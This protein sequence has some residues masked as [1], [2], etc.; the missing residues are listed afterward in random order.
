VKGGGGV[1][2]KQRAVAANDGLA[3]QCLPLQNVQEVLVDEFQHLLEQL[4]V[5]TAVCVQALHHALPSVPDDLMS[6]GHVSHKLEG[7]V[8]QLHAA[9]VLEFSFHPLSNL[10]RGACRHGGGS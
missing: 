3:S 1:R 5:F 8:A 9:L 4:R 7:G 6:G 2:T 10:L